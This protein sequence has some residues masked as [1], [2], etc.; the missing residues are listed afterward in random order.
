MRRGSPNLAIA[1]ASPHV[2]RALPI[3][4]GFDRSIRRDRSIAA[5][6][7]G[8]RPARPSGRAAGP[9][10]RKAPAA[11]SAWRGQLAICEAFC[12]T[13]RRHAF[14]ALRLAKIVAARGG[15]SGNPEGN[16]L[17]RPTHVR[18]ER[19]RSSETM[20]PGSKVAKVEC[21][22]SSSGGSSPSNSPPAGE[23]CHLA[24]GL[25]QEARCP[26]PSS[27]LGLRSCGAC[28]KPVGCSQSSIYMAFDRPFCSTS[29]REKAVL[30]HFT[31]SLPAFDLPPSSNQHFSAVLAG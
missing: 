23:R 8:R 15:S 9:T 30:E 16:A 18:M 31:R 27:K 24:P 26:A 20:Q 14:D 22:E 4:P 21:S 19:E 3:D 7:V 28:S 12:G 25:L 29:C 5:A 11:R 1:E 10:D 17:G 6:A 2:A 13:H